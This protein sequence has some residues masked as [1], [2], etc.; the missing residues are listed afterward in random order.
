MHVGVLVYSVI[1]KTA[2]ISWLQLLR[3]M[4][5]PISHQ[6]SGSC[7]SYNLSAPSSMHSQSLRL[8]GR[9][10]NISWNWVAHGQLLSAFGPTVSPSATNT[11]LLLCRKRATFTFNCLIILSFPFYI[12]YL[13]KSK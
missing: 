1:V 7:G 6:V 2:E 11:K 13:T 8:R 4:Q 3:Y 5:D 9:F 10:V 12:V